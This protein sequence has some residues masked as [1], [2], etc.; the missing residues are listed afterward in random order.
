MKN[1][2]STPFRPRGI[3]SIHFKYVLNF[4]LFSFSLISYAQTDT[5]TQRMFLI[6]DAGQ[7]E[8]E[9]HPVLEWLRKNVN[10]N[11]EKNAAVFLGDNIY[12]DGLTDVGDPQYPLTKKVIDLQMSLVMGKK[13]KV[14]FVPGNHDW[15][16]GK[17]GGWERIINQ[18]NYINGLQQNN[19][20]AW[21]LNGCPGPVPIEINEKVVLVMMDSQWFLH[22]N[23]K[24][25]LES[26][27]GARTIDEFTAQLKE[28]AAT[29][30]NQLLILAMH[31][32]MYTYGVHGGAYGLRQHFFPFSDAIKGLYIPLP[33]LGSVYPLARGLFGSL[34]DTYHPLYRTMINEIE[35]ALKDH[36]NVVT[37]SGHEHSMQL[38]VKD[39]ITQIVS[40]SAA[41]LTRLRKGKNSLFSML[42]YG[43]AMI[44]VRKSGQLDVK[45]YNLQSKNLD[46]PVFSKPLKTIVPFV[47]DVAIDTTLPV[48]KNVQVEAS[49]KMRSSGFERLVWG[50][51]Y[52]K[53]W[54]QFIS[55]PMLDV[56]TEAG[57]LKAIKQDGALQTKALLLTEKNGKQ[58]SLRPLEKFPEAVVPAD[59]RATLSDVVLDKGIS[60][61]Y[62]YASLSLPILE[63]AAG[64]PAVRK[65]LVYVPDDPRL[66]RFRTSFKNTMAL[67]EEK[68]PI[69]TFKTYSTEDLLLY[70]SNDSKSRVDQKAV[71]L[72]R[73]MDNF[74]MDFDR[75]E[76]KWIWA[77]R[78]SGQIKIFT[79][80]P[81]ESDQAFFVN[82]G[83]MAYFLRQQWFIPQ[84]QGFRAKAYNIRTFNKTAR[85]FDRFFLSGLSESTWKQVI[86]TFLSKM[87]DEVIESAFS[88]QPEEVRH[89]N[90]YSLIQKLK[91]RRKY[92]REEMLSY[93]RFISKTVSIAGTRQPEYYNIKKLA[94]GKVSVTVQRLS[95]ARTPIDTTYQRLFDPG[96]TKELRIYALEGNDSV[97]VAGNSAT[98]RIRII[99]G[100]GDDNFINQGKGKK[101]LIYDASFENNSIS[102]SLAGFKDMTSSNPEI[103][104]YNRTGF[105]YN[106]I[107]PGTKIHFNR[108]EGLSLKLSAEYFRQGF[109]KEPYGMRQYVE[110][111]KSF[112]TGSNS[113]RYESDFI[114]AIKNVDLSIR[115]DV[116][117]PGYVSNFFGIGNNTVFEKAKPGEIGYY[118][119][120]YNMVTASIL[121]GKQLQSWMRAGIGPVFQ[122]IS[123]SQARNLYKYLN[124]TV[125]N[126]FDDANAYNPKSFLGAEGR[127]SINSKNNAELPTRGAQI[128]VY[129]RQ[130]FGLN[131]S[132]KS[133]LQSGLDIRIFMSFVPKTKIVFATR[134][135]L[136]L[137]FGHFEFPQAQYLSGTENLRGFRRE[138]FAGR[139]ML[140][141]NSEIR[142]KL[143][144]FTTYLFKGS[145]GI[146]AFHDIGRVWVPNERSQRWHT[147]YGG[148]I[149]VAPIARFVI[150]GS[151]AFSKEESLIP[152]ITF[153]FQF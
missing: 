101:I 21:P 5:I 133:L 56:S 86:D 37:A 25:G 120:H 9:H 6:G 151:A 12:P 116:R 123:V 122:S 8:G 32:P 136:G 44:E 23:D 35:N 15:K 97:V 3:L 75:H 47:S 38:I 92:F 131:S 99:G 135:G 55:I 106:Y 20:Q 93:Y 51:N 17:I 143:I 109:R 153:G 98:I 52:R 11:D 59:L 111:Y 83:I 145:A 124:D 19:I 110:Y 57:G 68:E 121:A 22:I 100:P 119:V 146:L 41:K 1:T 7:M 61:G 28:I 67:L 10:W 62:P 139:T 84:I 95:I 43:F 33:G 26:G 126:G 46:N 132:S 39:S 49:S 104:R 105:K 16:G 14:F 112:L 34:Q 113:F 54:K 87:S 125:T 107:A 64:I 58:W 127:L 73:L 27:C 42:D 142:W 88:Q 128:T 85:D 130:L 103:N 70:L 91:K 138:R 81:K 114:K 152:L 40:G 69:G 96:V 30:K 66:D 31:H 148:G 48:L 74:V 117:A 147:G 82:E 2:I 94:D 79:P 50:G 140:F 36:P 102:D 45:F 78:D 13:G 144:D 90:L 129:G 29:H 80:I 134:F 60:G 149:W 72:A 4:L 71:L 141:N 18:V 118:R 77:T 76:G 24:P 150:V 115:A 53:E 108:D 137:N 63:K 89:L 65:K